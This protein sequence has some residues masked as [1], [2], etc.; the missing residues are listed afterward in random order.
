MTQPTSRKGMALLLV[1]MVIVLVALAAYGYLD[2]MQSQYRMA[3]MQLEQTEAKLTAL[4][5]LEQC[6]S[7]LDRPGQMRQSLGSL[8]D[9]IALFGERT[10]ASDRANETTDVEP[11][12]FSVLSPPIESTGPNRTTSSLPFRYGMENESAKLHIPTLLAWDRLQPG[13]AKRALLNLP[14][15]TDEM[16]TIFLEYCRAPQQTPKQATAPD[17]IAWLWNGGDWNRNYRLD[18]LEQQLGTLAQKGSTAE[19]DS[20]SANETKTPTAWEHFLTWESGQR[21]VSWTGQQRI[22]LNQPDL[23]KLHSELI[24]VW[25]DSWANYVVLAR[26]YGVASKTTSGSTGAAEA[27]PAPDF[28]LPAKS[29]FRTPLDLLDT[30]V[31]IPSQSGPPQLI[32]SPFLSEMAQQSDYLGK[33]LDDVTVS[34][35]EFLVGVVDVNSAPVEVLMGIPGVSSAIAQ[36]IV[37]VR[38]SQSTSPTS[39][40]YHIGWLFTQS[41]CNL[42]TLKQL[43]PYLAARSDVYQ[44]QVIGYR[45]DL[46]PTFRAS[47]VIDG[48]VTPTRV[49]QFQHWQNWGRF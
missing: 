31:R 22:F 21:N 34:S 27:I 1:S 9:N 17:R 40:A 13:S 25:P 43:Y 23:Q 5:G 37:Q 29:T 7:L 10:L 14:G 36:R 8:E 18:L 6:A 19:V 28:Q 12:R 30:V 16:V 45:D 46:S 26:Q 32:V 41:V 49:R 38:Q 39:E 3:K 2:H 11:W 42:Q 33:L 48:R 4:S 47:A 44:V 24:A 20:S 15:A 35:T